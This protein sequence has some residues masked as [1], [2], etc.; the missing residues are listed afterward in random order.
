MGEGERI[1]RR[2]FLKWFAVLSV[3]S[4]GGVGCVC[5]PVV[6]YGPPPEPEYGPL[7]VE[8]PVVNRITYLDKEGD[9]KTLQGSTDVPPSAQ[10]FIYFSVSMDESSQG[11]VSFGNV[12]GEG[13]S[14]ETQWLQ[15]DTLEV[16][17][18]VELEPGAEYVLEV[19]EGAESAYGEPLLLT[20]IARAEFTVA[21]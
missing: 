9:E 18:T 15:E 5:V 14:F 8:G 19:G 11:A 16:V 3:T 2:E 4:V 17:L 7:P 13:V 12:E 1:S 21:E 6:M 10:F 20:G